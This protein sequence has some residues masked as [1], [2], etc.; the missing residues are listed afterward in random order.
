MF[1]TALRKQQWLSPFVEHLIT[2]IIRK[3]VKLKSSLVSKLFKA[4]LKFIIVIVQSKTEIVQAMDIAQSAAR[5]I[6][7]TV[8]K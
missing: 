3:L 1:E 2:L 8:S 5:I 7:E 6:G 4:G